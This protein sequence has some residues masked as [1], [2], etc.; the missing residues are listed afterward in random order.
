MAN[1][2]YSLHLA[3]N[4]YS[5]YSEKILKRSADKL[6]NMNLFQPVDDATNFR[7]NLGYINNYHVYCDYWNR[8]LLTNSQAT[9]ENFL[10]GF[11]YILKNVIE[12]D[13]VVISF[14][15]HG[16]Y[17][18]FSKKNFW[19][20]YD[21][22][23]FD[24]EIYQLLRIVPSGVRVVLI[25]D[26]C[27]SRGIIDM[28]PENTDFETNKRLYERLKN[29]NSS[30]ADKLKSFLAQKDNKTMNCDLIHISATASDSTS[31]NDSL[32]FIRFLNKFFDEK[33]FEYSEHHYQVYKYVKDKLRPFFE[34]NAKLFRTLA[35]N[36]STELSDESY[37]PFDPE[38]DLDVLKMDTILPSFNR[39]G[40]ISNKQFQKAF[41]V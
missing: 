18:S 38:N 5:Y 9:L 35:Y 20:L 34:D 41:F 7:N 37:L 33:G 4:D 40:K 8:N 21:E 25:S 17:N 36:M 32:S 12:G 30:F 1:W 2:A 10:K 13:L 29:I 22:R 23:L 26:S 15:G 24:H 11:I 6:N 3:V 19:S 28:N 14:S 39:F 31:V 16:T 27:Q